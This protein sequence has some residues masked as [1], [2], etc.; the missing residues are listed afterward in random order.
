MQTE[1]STRDSGRM[2]KLMVMAATLMRMELPMLES[3]RTIS[4]TGKEWKLGRMALSMKDNT[5]KERST[6]REPSHLQMAVCIQETLYKMKLVAKV[7]MFGLTERLTKGN[8][9]RI[10]CMAME[11]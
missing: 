8:G 5:L 10:R 2:T 3:G 11:C 4:N 7:A 6:A 1:I 9:K